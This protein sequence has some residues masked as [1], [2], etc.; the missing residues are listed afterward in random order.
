M[1]IN[2]H[3]YKQ[4]T[5]TVTLEQPSN[6]TDPVPLHFVHHRSPRADAIPF[7]FIHGWPGSFLEVDNI[8][9]GLLNPN[10]KSS[11]AF[12]VVAPSIPGFAFSPAPTKPGFAT[13]E[14]GNAF[15]SLMQQLG[16]TQFVIQ[17]GD[18]GAGILR[19][20]AADYPS[21]VVSVLSNFWITPPNA[22]D[23][24]RY[25]EGV[26]SADENTVIQNFDAITNLGSGYRFIMQ[27]QP[28]QLAIGMTDSP[29][30]NAMWL[31]NEMRQAVESYIWPVDQI[32]TWTM[33]YYIQGPYGG[34]RFYKE[35]LEEVWHLVRLLSMPKVYHH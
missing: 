5:T 18:F 25:Q 32:I 7:L 33:M 31:Y 34:M 30:G 17:A 4:F 24:E 29:L 2:C 10:D 11:P 14:A 9:D 8:L 16:Y 19:I 22:T 23:L 28:L 21:S 20:M 27:L 13:R 15:H 1:N 6:F 35:A 12:H 3:R 26:T